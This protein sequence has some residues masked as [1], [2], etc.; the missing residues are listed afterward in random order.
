M[1]GLGEGLP[2]P[3]L[4]T[5]EPTREPGTGMNRNRAYVFLFHV[6][7]WTLVA[8]PS[9]TVMSR[10]EQPDATQYLLRL[11]FPLL[12]CAIFYTNFLW[13]VPRYLVAGRYRAFVAI[14]IVAILLFAFLSMEAGEAMHLREAALDIG[15]PP[16]IHK[17]VFHSALGRAV[18]DV[19]RSVFPLLIS[20]AVAVLLRLAMRWQNAERARKEMEIQKTE[21]EL[22]NLRNQVNPHFLLN[23][24]NN[25]YALISIDAGKAQKA[26]LSLSDMLRQMLYRDP[27]ES[28]SLREETDFIRNYIDLMRIRMSSNVTVDVRISIPE[29]DGVR[30]AP[31]TFI[32]LVENAFKHGVSPTAPSFISI[33]VSSD[34]R[35]IV[36]DIRNSNFPKNVTDRSGHGIGLEQVARRLE[37]SYRDRY[38]WERGVEDD[39][40]TYFSKITIHDTQLRDYR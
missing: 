20:S 38:E 24:L 40:R 28:V 22:S 5:N 19:F 33:D 18:A 4:P 12:M 32:S 37:L 39:G 2:P 16:H 36:C 35:D 3:S 14:D 13:L 7:C 31:F 34:G 6:V 15:R 11:C 27:R 25:I 8:R 29:G 23:T 21:A 30:I 9:I 26:V 17:E 1:T 10:H